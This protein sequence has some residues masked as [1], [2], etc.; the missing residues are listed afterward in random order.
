MTDTVREPAAP[1]AP[2]P[3]NGSSP[4]RRLRLSWL[5]L[6][7]VLAIGLVVGASGDRG[8]RTTEERVDAVAETVRCP[9]C[10]SQAAADSDA[11]SGRAVVAEIGEQVEA[12]RTDDEIRAYFADIYGEQILLTPSGSGFVGLVWVLPVVALVLGAAGLAVTFRRW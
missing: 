1:P 12:G 3:T 6:L 7:V 11:A 9:T 5:A 10:R 2:G 4:L 8:P